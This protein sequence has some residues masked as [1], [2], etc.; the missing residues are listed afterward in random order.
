MKEHSHPAFSWCLRPLSAWLLVF[1]LGISFPGAG[2]AAEPVS[3]RY[4]QSEGRTIQ[5]ELHIGT[6]PPAMLILVQRFSQGAV[7]KAASPPVQKFSSS[8]DEAKWL[9]KRLQAGSMVFTMELEQPVAAK[10]VSGEIRYK[11]PAS[12]KTETMQVAP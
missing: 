6:P 3:C 10:A 1:V 5:L 2:S 7:I 9:L 4:L 11:D 12:G 8:K